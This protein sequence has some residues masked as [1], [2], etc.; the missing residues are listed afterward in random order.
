MTARR[1]MEL[2]F[3]RYLSEI[4]FGLNAP[5]RAGQHVWKPEKPALPQIA[6]LK[7]PKKFST[8]LFKTPTVKKF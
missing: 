1:K 7:K 8:S 2:N 3:K 5:G 4:S 6:S